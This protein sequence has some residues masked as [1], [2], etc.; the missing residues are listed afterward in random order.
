LKSDAEHASPAAQPALERLLEMTDAVQAA[1][2]AGEWQRAAQLESERRALLERYL[3]LHG[4]LDGDARVQ[5]V[6]V[7]LHER[8]NGMIGEVHHHRR[9]LEHEACLIGRGKRAVK[10]YGEL[11]DRFETG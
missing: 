6:L 2:G 10:A 8:N 1:I 9:R 7:R 11:K 5:E 4:A 3:G